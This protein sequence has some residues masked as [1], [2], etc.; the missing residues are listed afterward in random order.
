MKIPVIINKSSGRAEFDSILN[1]L[2]TELSE[3]ELL[4]HS[5]EAPGDASRLASEYIKEEAKYIIVVGGD[6]TL[7]EAIQPLV[8]SSKVIVPV[9]AGTGSDFCRALNIKSVEDSIHAITDGTIKSFDTVLCRWG[10][11]GRYFINILEL[12]FGAS[13][14]E[15]VNRSTRKDKGVFRRSVLRQLLSLKNYKVGLTIDRDDMEVISPEIII[16][17]GVYFGGGM[18]A[19]P[20]SSFTDGLIDIHIIEKLGRLSLLRRFPKLIDGTY[21]RD[22]GVINTQG[23]SIVLNGDCPIEMDG[24]VVGRLP[25]KIEVVPASILIGIP[26]SSV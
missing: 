22:S 19:S 5:T 17:N 6:G 9:P 8:G 13:V 25:M 23:K 24:E 21:I 26:K 1:S 12:G 4:I 20:E 2:E 18:K 15:R 11:R 10:T 3:H 7:N 16:A 14:M